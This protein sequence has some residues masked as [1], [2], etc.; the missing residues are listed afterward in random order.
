ME[1]I[2]RWVHTYANYYDGSQRLHNNIYTHIVLCY[3]CILYIWIRILF[4]KR[5]DETQTLNR[6]KLIA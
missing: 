3:V 1:V 4:T 2:Y 6:S 5:E